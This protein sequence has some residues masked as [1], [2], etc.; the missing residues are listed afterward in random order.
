[1]SEPHA[2]LEPSPPLQPAHDAQ[3]PPV[4]EPRLAVSEIERSIRILRAL[5]A[6]V[7][8]DF[9]A[10]QPPVADAALV[11]V[12]LP[13]YNARQWIDLCL[14]GILAQSHANLEVLCVDDASTDDTYERVVSRFGRDRR[15]CVVRLARNVGPYQ[16][17]NWGIARGRGRWVALHDADDVSHPPRLRE[18]L[19]WLHEQQA[20]ACG[21]CVHQVHPPHIEPSIRGSARLEANG[22]HHDLAIYELVEPVPAS[23]DLREAL[24]ARPSPHALRPHR[25][26][27]F[28]ASQVI[29]RSLLLEFGGFDGHARV[30]ADTELNRRLIRF[31]AIGNVPRVLCSRHFHDGS[32]TQDPATG[33]ASALRRAYESERDHRVV[34]IRRALLEGDLARAREFSTSTLYFG[35]VRIAEAHTGFDVDL[36]G[37]LRQGA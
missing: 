11:T 7:P 27:A 19:R 32:L 20:R 4:F 18:Q 28:Y 30:G 23:L 29:E 17:R 8:Q 35:D 5:S 21:V 22:L 1:M 9:I 2:Q 10:R 13:M 34:Q 26:I 3:R 12:V 16:I 33:R 14:T 37:P 15:L 36:A 31:H 25:A 6:L 24:L